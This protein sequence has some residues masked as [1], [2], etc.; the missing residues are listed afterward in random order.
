MIGEDPHT[1]SVSVSVS[2]EIPRI[3]LRGSA[4]RKGDGSAA[5]REENHR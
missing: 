5:Y 3:E 4:P 2:G 1:V